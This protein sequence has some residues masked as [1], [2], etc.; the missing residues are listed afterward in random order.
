[1]DAMLKRSLVFCVGLTAACFEV[2]PVGVR[3]IDAVRVTPTPVSMATGQ[4]ISMR[5]AVL[6]EF[7]VAFAG[8]PVRWSSEDEAT[9]VVTQ[10]G[11]VTA[12]GRGVTKIIAMADSVSG[13]A[14][15][16]VTGPLQ[17]Y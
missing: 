8:V 15:V 3:E 16:Q 5:A 17:S 2:D 12:L 10:T 1:M 13:V 14:D 4:S 7:G 9:V 6:D 11:M